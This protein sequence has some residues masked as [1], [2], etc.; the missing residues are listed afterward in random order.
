MAVDPGAGSA[1]P[2]YPQSWNRYQYARNRPLVLIDPDGQQER[3]PFSNMMGVSSDP[4][5]A[6]DQ[7]VSQAMGETPGSAL[8]TELGPMINESMDTLGNLGEGVGFA[9]DFATV[10][11]LATA[12]ALPPSAPVTLRL[13]GAFLILGATADGVAFATDPTNPERAALGANLLGG[14]A[15]AATSVIL[16]QTA[17]ALSKQVTA[18][19]LSTEQAFEAASQPAIENAIEDGVEERNK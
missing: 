4:T 7:F 8:G 13:A 1:R 11:L 3:I 18:G 9:A 15:G 10:G 17:P 14:G 6:A 5:R 12:L 19:V 16:K 2:E